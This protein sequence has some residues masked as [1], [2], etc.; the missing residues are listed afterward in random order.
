MLSS[1]KSPIPKSLSPFF[2]EYNLE[3]LDLK[4]SAATII[5]RV[6]QY[7]TRTEIRWLFQIYPREKIRGWVEKWGNYALPEPH[8]SFWMLVLD[9]PESANE[10]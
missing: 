9:L 6:L 4:R 2:Q 7:G 3:K 8:L 5:E 1:T 10:N